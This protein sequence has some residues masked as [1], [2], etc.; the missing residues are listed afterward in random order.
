MIARLTGRLEVQSAVVALMLGLAGCGQRA[1]PQLESLRRQLLLDVEPSHPTTVAA[2][3]EQPRDAEE[4]VLVGRIDAGQFDPFDRTLAAFTLSDLPQDE[5]ATEGHDAATCPFCKRR[6]AKAPRA[7]V[8]LVGS[9]GAPLRIPAPELLGLEKGQVVVA[10][11]RGR[12]NPELNVY[13]LDARQVFL[14][15]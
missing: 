7:F 4:V 3:M 12:A 5:H 13:Q 2:L 9:D 1:D 11:G 14:R 8:Q 6:A 10:L 15:K